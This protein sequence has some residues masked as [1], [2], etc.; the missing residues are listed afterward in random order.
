[1]PVTHALIGCGNWGPAHLEWFTFSNRFEVAWVIDKREEA[2]EAARAGFRGPRYTTDYREMLADDDVDSVSVVTNIATHRTLVVDCAR[3]GKHVLVEKPMTDSMESAY[4]MVEA[5]EK[6]GVKLMVN[7]NY[8]WF[9]DV[10]CAKRVVDE[11]DFGQLKFANIVF[12]SW[13]GLEN[14]QPWRE[15][16]HLDRCVILSHGVHVLDLLRHLTGKEATN[17]SCLTQR[18]DPDFK[19]ETS[20]FMHMM[21]ESDVPACVRL[22]FAC[23]GR[24]TLVEGNHFYQ[25]ENGHVKIGMG[26]VPQVE[27]VLYGEPEERTCE[28]AL[29]VNVENILIPCFEHFADCIE[30]NTEP[31]TSGRDNL[32]TMRIITGAYESAAR[33]GELVH[34]D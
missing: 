33:A 7:Q 16:P 24:Q 9:R 29:T 6:N 23:K 28:E 34:L 21:L 22:G 18:T 5:A 15:E 19:G 8:R 12:Y 30:R 20:A 2:L 14:L 25:F 26:Q 4:A 3:A 13:L 27:A 10:A 11:Y 32:G 17:I 31:L 1:M